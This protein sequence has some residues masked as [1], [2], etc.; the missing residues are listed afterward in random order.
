MFNFGDWNIIC[1]KC[2]MKR[3]ASECSLNWQNQL[4]CGPCWE[5]RHPQE[6]VKGIPD[7]QSVPIARPD[8]VAIQGETTVKTSASRNATSI[9]LTSITGLVDKDPINIILNDGSAYWVYC[10][11]TPSSDTV[12]FPAGAYLPFAASAGNTVYLPSLDNETYITATTLVE[13]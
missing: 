4:V 11:G 12:T 1:E 8:V 10:E 2:G 5:S 9:E 3:K 7:N 13:L 6:Y